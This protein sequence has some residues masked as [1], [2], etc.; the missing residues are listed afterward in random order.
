MLAAYVF[1]ATLVNAMRA[2]ILERHRGPT[3]SVIVWGAIRYNTPSH[4]LRIEGNLYNNRYIRKVLQPEELPLIQA[5]PH[6]ILQ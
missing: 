2:C 1:D 4:L 3:P 6:A 5:T